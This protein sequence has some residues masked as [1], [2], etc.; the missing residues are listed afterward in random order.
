MSSLSSPVPVENRSSSSNLSDSLGRQLFIRN[1]IEHSE[2]EKRS[3]VPAIAPRHLLPPQEEETILRRSLKVISADIKK[4]E[5]FITITEDIIRREHERD[6][7]FYSRERK[8]KFDIGLRNM[9]NKSPDGRSIRA[10]VKQPT[11]RINSSKFNRKIMNYSPRTDKPRTPIGRSN[12]H[13]SNTID[14]ISSNM[15]EAN[16]IIEYIRSESEVSDQRTSYASDV[17]GILSRTSSVSFD[18]DENDIDKSSLLF[19]FDCSNLSDDKIVIEDVPSMETDDGIEMN[20]LKS[21]D[22]VIEV[23]LNVLNEKYVDDTIEC[24]SDGPVDELSYRDES[25][26]ENNGIGVENQVDDQ[27]KRDPSTTSIQTNAR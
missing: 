16:A 3:S 21:T 6:R 1:V 27:S 10:Q 8:R 23:E 4:M 20:K 7:D 19:D 12:I 5:D 25:N 18:L 26:A 9:S 2:K 14:E 13:D 11:Y 15:D 22:D 17:T 24:A